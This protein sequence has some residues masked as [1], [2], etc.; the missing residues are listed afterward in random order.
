[1]TG[2]IQHAAAWE[3]GQLMVNT[4]CKLNEIQLQFQFY[5]HAY[6]A[7][8]QH[9]TVEQSVQFAELSCVGHILKSNHF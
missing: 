2:S 1:M 8:I 7:F 3:L 6:M 5:I 9:K 4:K